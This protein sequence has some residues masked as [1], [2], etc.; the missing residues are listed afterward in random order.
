MISWRNRIC[1]NFSRDWQIYW[2]TSSSR[3]RYTRYM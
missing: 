3:S 1:R 2:R